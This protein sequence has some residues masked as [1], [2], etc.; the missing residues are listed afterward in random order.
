MAQEYAIDTPYMRMLQDI[1]TLR[2]EKETEFARGKDEGKEEGSIFA[3]RGDI[4]DILQARFG[5]EEKESQQVT[6]RLLALNATVL[7]R[8]LIQ[9]ATCPDKASFMKLLASQPE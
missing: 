9:A 1:E 3:R 8:T 5:I 4:I 7:A 2:E 6:E